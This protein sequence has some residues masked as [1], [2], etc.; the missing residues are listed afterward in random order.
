M[1]NTECFIVRCSSCMKDID[2]TNMV[3]FCDDVTTC[4]YCHLYFCEV[5]EIDNNIYQDTG[6]LQACVKCRSEF[7]FTHCAFCK[8]DID[9]AHMYCP[10]EEVCSCDWCDS[11]FCKDCELNDDIIE[12]GHADVCMKCLAKYP[13]QKD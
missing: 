1:C 9:I 7:P 11:Y 6:C 12:C 5:C 2:V 8:K 3:K 13:K 4:D 10:E